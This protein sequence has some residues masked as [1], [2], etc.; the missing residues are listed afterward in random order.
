MTINSSNSSM[1]V[2]CVDPALAAVAS[3]A[4]ASSCPC[5]LA[6]RVA[7]AVHARHTVTSMHAV[8]AHNSWSDTGRLQGPT[9]R[10]CTKGWGF[11]IGR[12]FS[13]CL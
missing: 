10:R 4:S 3:P 1:G 2:A 8:T 13:S 7:V 6:S 5:P 12:R 11:R 9:G